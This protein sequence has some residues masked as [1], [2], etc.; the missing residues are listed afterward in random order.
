MSFRGRR[1]RSFMRGRKRPISKHLFVVSQPAL[2]TTQVVVTPFTCTFPTT[3]VGFRWS[4]DVS[5]SITQNTRIVWALIVVP[6][7]YTANAMDMT[8]NGDFYTPEK[9]VIVF[10]VKRL[11]DAD[12]GSTGGP[13]TSNF[14]GTT[15]VSRRLQTGDSLQLIMVSTASGTTFEG[16]LQFFA[17]G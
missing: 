6:D 11:M 8:N 7:G 3:L 4:F 1:R 2:S 9:Q 15:K 17:Q 13:S 10:G 16:V 12:S 14:E 5:A